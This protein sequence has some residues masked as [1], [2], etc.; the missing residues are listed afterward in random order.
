MTIVEFLQ[1]R[2][3]EDERIAKES[4]AAGGQWRMDHNL[5]VIT[6]NGSMTEG[7][8]PGLLGQYAEHIARQD[9]ARVLREVAAKRA[10]LAEYPAGFDLNINY[11]V[12]IVGGREM[13]ARPPSPVFVRAL[14]ASYADHPEYQADWAL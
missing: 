10:I 12:V 8:Q 9:P 5:D 6:A 11:A 7:G 2:L 13:S 3:A 4:C 14:A 1:E